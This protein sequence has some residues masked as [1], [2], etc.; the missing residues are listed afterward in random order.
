VVGVSGYSETELRNLS[1]VRK[2]F[3]EEPHDGKKSELFA[4]DAVWWNG[5]P[6]IPGAE[7]RTEHRGREAIANILPSESTARPRPGADRYDLS[8]MRVSQVITLA[9]GDHVVRQQNFSATTRRGQHYENT[10]CF[11]FRFDDEG[12][13][14]YLT[15]H[16]NTW[17]AHRVLF[18]N[19]QPDPARPLGDDG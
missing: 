1:V 15:E 3:G 12:R 11:V 6:F 8:T 5:L 2:F 13:I 9:D 7:G 18:D 19:F 10:Y 17:H 14:A 4:E 16:W